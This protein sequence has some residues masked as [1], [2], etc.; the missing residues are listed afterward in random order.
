MT[1]PRLAEAFLRFE[2]DLRAIGI[3][4]ALVGGLAVSARAEPRTTRDIDVAIA[5]SDDP[6]AESVVRALLGRGYYDELVMDH[7]HAKRLSTVRFKRRGDDS[8]VFF[9][10]LFATAGIEREVVAAAEL[11]EVLPGL[12]S[13]VARTGHLLALKTLALRP[14]RPQERPQ[15][16]ADIRELLRVADGEE[17]RRARTALELISRRGFDRGKDLDVLFEG[18]LLQFRESQRD[19]RP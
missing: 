6:E 14:D 12:Y 5:A 15:D 17:L 3:S 18:Q 4:W 1:E 8:G 10:I 11:L 2:T 9:D 13:P 19:G 16:F 7:R